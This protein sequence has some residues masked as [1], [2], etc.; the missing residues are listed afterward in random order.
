MVSSLQQ[1]GALEEV[2]SRDTAG[3]VRDSVASIQ[4]YAVSGR[5]HV[6]AMLQTRRKRT[7]VEERAKRE[8]AMQALVALQGEVLS[9]KPP[10][11]RPTTLDKWD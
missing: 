6:C 1:E 5:H 4:W 9:S 8:A 7:L 11:Y 3:A 2:L 10:L